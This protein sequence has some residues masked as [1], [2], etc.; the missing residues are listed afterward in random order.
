MEAVH[1]VHRV[2]VADAFSAGARAP[3]EED[4]LMMRHAFPAMVF[5]LSLVF[6][7]PSRAGTATCSI[8]YKLP[9]DIPTTTSDATNST[10]QQFGWESFLGLNAPSVGGQIS[11]SGDNLPQWAAWSATV[12]LLLCQGSPT[13][14]GCTCP[15]DDCGSSGTRYYPDVCRGVPDYQAYRVLAQVGKIDDSFEEAATGGLSGDPVVDRFEGFLRYE[16]L[17]SPATYAEIIAEK[18]YDESELMARTA[19][20]NLACGMSSYT[21]GDPADAD[22]GALVVKLAW[23]D[24][25]DPPQGFDPSRYHREHFLVFTP[26]YRNS[27]GI[28]SC[29]IRT[30]AL[31]GMHIAHKTFNQPIWIWS[32]FEHDLNAPDCTDVYPAPGTQQ[33]NTSCPESVEVDY[34]FYGQRCNGQVQACSS[35][36][37]A[38]TANGNCNN[39]TTTTGSGYCLDLPPANN[40]G[41]SQLCRQIPISSYPEAATWNTACHDALGDDS[42]WSNYSL[43]SSQWGTS[44]IPAGCSN[45]SADVFPGRVD[46]SKILPKVAID[47]AMKPVLGN[48][49]MESYDRSNCIGCHAKGSFANDTGATLSTDM[50]YFLQLQVSA[51]AASRPAFAA[52]LE[53]GGGGGGG[54]CAVVPQRRG[55]GA[56]IAL[57]VLPLLMLRRRRRKPEV[58][59]RRSFVNAST[60]RS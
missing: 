40:G 9:A 24:V 51:P 41:I 46:D 55:G 2:S 60:L 22:M 16:I 25:T 31:V 56:W 34:N 6:A 53:S 15:N 44:A 26:D 4:G 36:N 28:E 45:V 37:T 58:S 30:M 10:F 39:P 27:D 3:E 35:C 14:D 17:L 54:G 59:T 32:T 1:F 49:A 33:A 38:P 5:A 42:V 43:I 29:G 12:D 13:P 47:S 7:A 23:M 48:T 57:A 11:T 20:V 18:L 50:M 52:D 8:D 19:D 21:G